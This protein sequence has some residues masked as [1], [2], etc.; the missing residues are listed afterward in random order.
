VEDAFRNVRLGDKNAMKAFSVKLSNQLNDLVAMVRSDLS[1]LQRKKVPYFYV[2]KSSKDV[3]LF[4]IHNY[5]FFN[6]KR[7]NQPY[8]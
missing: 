4:D 3:V 2:H 6:P 5:I 1:N 7:C 8:I